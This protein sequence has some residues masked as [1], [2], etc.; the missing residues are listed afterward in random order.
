MGCGMDVV[1]AGGFLGV[2]SGGSRNGRAY[3]AEVLQPTGAISSGV[4]PSKGSES[5]LVSAV[6][7]SAAAAMLARPRRKQVA[8]N[9]MLEE[10]E[11]RVMK[12][13]GWKFWYGEF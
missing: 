9:F 2:V 1:S 6:V 7:V 13:V 11:V 10:L 4:S 12:V 5:A 3:D 8:E